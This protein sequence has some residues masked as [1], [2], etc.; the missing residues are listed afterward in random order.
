M[1]A[2]KDLEILIS[3]KYPR[4]IERIK[5]LIEDSE[6]Q[7]SQEREKEK[8][9]VDS[10]LWEHTIHV[11]SI[12]RKIALAEEMDATDAVIA[13]LFHDSGKF[14][15]GHYH[16]K[17]VPEEESAAEIAQK[18]LAEEGMNP[19]KIET[20]TKAIKAL[21]SETEPASKMTN[22]LHDAD[23][24]AKFGYLGVANF[25]TKSALRGKTLYKAL[26]SSLSKELT[27]AVALEMNMR[28]A[29]G[30]KM[31]EKKSAATLSFYHGLLEELREGGIAFFQIKEEIF[32]CP[33]NPSKTFALLMAIPENCPECHNELTMDFASKAKTKCE[34]LTA[35]I[36]CVHCPNH[37]QVSFCLPEITK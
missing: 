31:A 11:A 2:K 5:Q 35:N 21:Y 20:I 16:D 17:E 18:L 25:F 24:L 22:A 6:R 28:T 37:Y 9:A 13:A 19:S 10:F 27:Y 23:F 30:K 4:L 14:F 1:R 32:P 26:V 12:A 36:N 33:D 34:Q 3:P 29:A 15:K 7:F 8:E